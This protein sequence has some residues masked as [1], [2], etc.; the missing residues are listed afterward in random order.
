MAE[1]VA[2]VCG[3]GVVGG[4]GI[5]TKTINQFHPNK[6]NGTAEAR[7]SVSFAFPFRW[8]Y[9]LVLERFIVLPLCRPASN[10]TCQ[11]T[12]I[13]FNCIV[14]ISYRW[15]NSTAFNIWSQTASQMSE[16][17]KKIICL[18]LNWRER[19]QES[20][21]MMMMMIMRML[22]ASRWKWFHSRCSISR[23]LCIFLFW[24]LKGN[25]CPHVCRCVS[26]A[27]NDAPTVRICRQMKRN[28]AYRMS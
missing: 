5:E 9:Q 14:N 24:L 15:L 17:L 12:L 28:L 16:V 18:G 25:M 20:L 27:D 22:M 26:A 11:A 8:F 19:I 21:M 23:W 3:V 4:C 7:N 1:C 2:M 6:N 13:A 10:T